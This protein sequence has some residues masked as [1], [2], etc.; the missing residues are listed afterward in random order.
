M[1]V[2][3]TLRTPLFGA[4]LLISCEF[5]RSDRNSGHERK[6]LAHV[7]DP[8]SSVGR[9]LRLCQIDQILRH[10]FSEYA[11]S[12]AFVTN[13]IALNDFRRIISRNLSESGTIY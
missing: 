8:I 4:R 11:G 3:S 6:V 7:A 13:N 9:Y 12:Y 5:L 1:V 10:P 2:F